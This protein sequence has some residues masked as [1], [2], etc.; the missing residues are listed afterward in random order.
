[1]TS[2]AKGTERS[3]APTI[4]QILTAAELAAFRSGFSIER[5]NQLARLAVGAQFPAALPT[6][7]MMIFTHTGGP[8]EGAQAPSA[9][10]LS[11]LPSP[12]LLSGQERERVIIALMTANPLDTSLLAIHIYWGLMEGLSPEEIAWTQLLT[13][14]YC[15][16]DKFTIGQKTLATTLLAM[17]S[18]LP[19]TDVDSVLA[20]IASGYAAS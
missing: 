14:A 17:R 6:L 2:T 15:G 9:G 13:A 5:L 12:S 1:M 8:I 18:C 20:A 16:I 19:R 3:S 4:D 10:A 7:N 11:E